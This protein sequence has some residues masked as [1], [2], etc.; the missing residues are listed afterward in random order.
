M[1]FSFVLRLYFNRLPKSVC[2]IFRLLSAMTVI[3]AHAALTDIVPLCSSVSPFL[4]QNLYKNPLCPFR[5]F[6]DFY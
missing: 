4:L 2:R 1:I 3:I 5:I 6:F